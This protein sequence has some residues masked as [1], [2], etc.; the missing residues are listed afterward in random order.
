M[1]QTSLLFHIGECKTPK[2]SWDK[3]AS[4]F[5]KVNE[6][7]ALQLEAKLSSLVPDEHASIEDYLAKFRLLVA[8]LK[9]CGKKKSD[10]ECI[11]LILSKLKGPFQVF[12]ST[13]YSTMDALGD[14]FKMPSFELFVSVLPGN[15]LS[16]CN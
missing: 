15:N 16:L 1:F 11:F 14:E 9:G 2:E 8:Q 5:G 7:Q 12:S 3:L 13:F 4:L 10:D 6:F